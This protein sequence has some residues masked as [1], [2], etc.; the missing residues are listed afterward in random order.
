MKFDFLRRYAF[1]A[2]S[3]V[4]CE[5]PEEDVLPL[6]GQTFAVILQFWEKLP[7]ESQDQVRKMVITLFDRYPRQLEEHVHSLP[8]LSNIMAMQE[9][10][11]REWKGKRIQGQRLGDF[12]DRCRNENGA[13]VEQALLELSAFLQQ[14]QLFIHNTAM[15]EQPD[16]A[17]PQIIRCLLD[18]CVQYKDTDSNISRISAECLGII[19][20]VDPSKVDA[21]RNTKQITV[22]HNFEGTDESPEFVTFLLEHRL[23]KAF[24]A[25]TDTKAQG[26]L[27][28]SMQELLKVCGFDENVLPTRCS[29]EAPMAKRWREFSDISRNTLTPYLTSKYVLQGISPAVRAPKHPIYNPD[30]TYRSWLQEFLFDLMS[31]VQGD[32]A[33]AIFAICSRIIKGQD[34]AIQDFILPYVT[35]NVVISGTDS[36]REEISKELLAI[37]EHSESPKHPLELETLRECSEVKCF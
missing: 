28:H 6:V 22:L 12:A 4:M 7:S 5:L 8:P 36:D 10:T 1:S 19:G 15:S 32:I 20:A 9:A 27:A 26:F 14:E 18:A 34:I 31:K 25:A 24:L 37:V 16:V 3:S 13:V 23:V 29:S 17:I 2:W 11:I 30:H 33:S 35:L 21:L